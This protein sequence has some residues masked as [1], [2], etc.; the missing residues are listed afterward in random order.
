[1][2]CINYMFLLMSVS[3]LY[4]LLITANSPL[5]LQTHGWV[6]ATEQEN[7]NQE[8]A[9]SSSENEDGPDETNSESESSKGAADSDQSESNSNRNDDDLSSANQNSN[10]PNITE[11]SNLP[12]YI[13]QDG[14][15]YPC[16]SLDSNDQDNVLDGCPVEPSSQT[17][18]GFS[19]KE[20]NPTQMPSQQQQQ[21][22]QDSPNQNAFVS[23]SI[24]SDTSTAVSNSEAPTTTTQK[25][26]TPSGKLRGGST[27]T[28]SSIPLLSNDVSKSKPSDS[29]NA[30]VEGTLLVPPSQTES[31]I[32]S[33]PG[34]PSKQFDPSKPF[35]PTK[36]FTSGSQT[37]PV[38][39][40]QGDAH[41]VVYSNFTKAKSPLIAKY[42]VSTYSSP[43]I[44]FIRNEAQANPYCMDADFDGTFHSVRA[45]GLV[46]IKVIN[47]NFDI[48]D[49]G[50]KIYIYPKESKSCLLNFINK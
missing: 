24:N 27:Q 19:V 36:P 4:A 43:A 44:K 15:E 38:V 32:P 13:G 28:E 45:P 20:E 46:E 21:N 35:T 17:N 50:C 30:K 47:S 40:F 39:G 6:Y 18:T 10:C 23:P 33:L 31:S 29:K 2:K 12:L 11:I 16:P 14:C 48:V 34:D 9:Q 42:C 5:T 26:F 7:T 41:L 8:E 22:G 3:F 49:N 25:S 37:S 1:M